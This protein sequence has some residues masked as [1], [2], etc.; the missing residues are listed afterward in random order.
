MA[1][2]LAEDPPPL[3]GIG[4]AMPMQLGRV[5]ERCLPKDPEER[6]KCAGDLASALRGVLSNHEAP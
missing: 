4:L 5:V 3:A 1:A 6:F 2:V